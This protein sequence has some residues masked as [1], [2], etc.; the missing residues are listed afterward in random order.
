MSVIQ[1]AYSIDPTA[2]D[3]W[4]LVGHYLHMLSHHEPRWRERDAVAA[5]CRSRLAWL[6]VENGQDVTVGIWLHLSDTE[7]ECANPDCAARV[8]YLTSD[9]EGRLPRS[10]PLPEFARRGEGLA[11]FEYKAHPHCD[12]WAASVDPQVVE[13]MNTALALYG[14][15]LR[16]NW[17]SYGDASEDFAIGVGHTLWQITDHHETELARRSIVSGANGITETGTPMTEDLAP[18]LPPEV[19]EKLRAATESAASAAN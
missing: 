8:Q 2:T 19:A 6:P 11:Y 16:V 7:V 10:G 9:G 12:G 13:W 3:A 15:Y 5:N 14:G 17:M 18:P 1:S 4:R